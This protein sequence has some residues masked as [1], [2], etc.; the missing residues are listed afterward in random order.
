MDVVNRYLERLWI[1]ISA[2][3]SI[4][5]HDVRELLLMKAIDNY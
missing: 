2:A 5:S 4:K 3:L 1:T